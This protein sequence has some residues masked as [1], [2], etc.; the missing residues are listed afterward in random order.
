MRTVVQRVDKA[1][2]EIKGR[3]HAS[4]GQDLMVLLGVVEIDSRNRE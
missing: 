4:I 3:P 1:S 2:V